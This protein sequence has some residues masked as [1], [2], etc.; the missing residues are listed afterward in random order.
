[1]KFRVRKRSLSR[2]PLVALAVWSVFYGV[3]LGLPAVLGVLMVLMETNGHHYVSLTSEWVGFAILMYAIPLGADPKLN[4]KPCGVRLNAKKSPELFARL[5]TMARAAGRRL[6]LEVILTLE[7]EARL[8]RV[9][10]V[11]GIGGKWVIFLGLPLLQTLPIPEFEAIVRWVFANPPTGNP[12]LLR[13]IA[14]G[15]DSIERSF[16]FFSDDSRL[17]DHSRRYRRL[18]RR[19]ATRIEGA[20]ERDLARAA[21]E[22][23]GTPAFISAVQ[24]IELTRSLA[25]EYLWWDIASV[26]GAGYMAPFVEG[27]S[28]ILSRSGQPTN[29]TPAL[30][31]LKDLPSLERKLIA[32]T[33]G[34]KVKKLKPIAWA[35]VGR[36]VWMPQWNDDVRRSWLAHK[37][38]GDVFDYATDR[39]GRRQRDALGAALACTLYR[40]GWHLD[41]GPG[42]RTFKKGDAELNPFETVTQINNGSI[43]LLDWIYRMRALKLNPTTPLYA[44][45]SRWYR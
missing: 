8:E 36:S 2:R 43:T 5:R 31:L 24:N 23:S 44:P 26:V 15:H 6:P 34:I 7:M 22:G 13:R 21:A 1:M 28:E 12:R 45:S 3:F 33:F 4:G 9:G 11:M 29:G 16:S 39:I 19:T 25:D 38:L 10:G 32:S 40:A 42:I 18:F 17:Q 20:R 27:F 41:S 35:D 14:R 30:S 37:S